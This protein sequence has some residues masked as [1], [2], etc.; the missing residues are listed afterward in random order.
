MESMT[1]G[2]RIMTLRKEQGLTQEQLAEKL[3]VS[4][5]AVSKWEN[6]ISCPDISILPQLADILHVS[7]DELLGAKP[8]E[9]RVVVVDSGK[10]EKTRAGFSYSFDI[11][12][13]GGILFAVALVV[14]GAAF[15]LQKLDIISF[16]IWNIVW[17]AVLIGV[18]ISWLVESF[19]IFGLG[20]A[21]LGLYYLLFNLGATNVQLSWSIIW[22]VLLVLLGISILVE[23][24]IKKRGCHKR[25]WR[26]GGGEPV[27]EYSESEGSVHASIAFCEDN[28]KVTS[29]VFAGGK[30]D[31][32]FGK[33][34]LDL[35]GCKRVEPGA[36]LDVNVAFSSFEL[37]V[38]RSI[39]V[40]AS[41]DRAFGSFTIKGTPEANATETL[42]LKG[43]VAFGGIIVR[44][45]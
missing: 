8:I 42:A 16:G 9:P 2:K 26:Q 41:E 45:I 43:D 44:Y 39:R 24:L 22:P 3:G 40:N 1:M 11:G 35:T 38:P 18:G 14:V 29:E 30:I 33:C 12:R 15:L 10:K 34:V 37:L 21:L 6:D 28:R 31:I 25:A 7:A 17:P 5:Q 27:S 20:V 23:K 36:L 4:A 32:S 19:S 13:R